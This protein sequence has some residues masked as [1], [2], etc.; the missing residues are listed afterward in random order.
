MIYGLVQIIFISRIQFSNL[1]TEEGY[2][3][4]LGESFRNKELLHTGDGGLLWLDFEHQCRSSSRNSTRTRQRSRRPHLNK[5]DGEIWRKSGKMKST[6]K[7]NKASWQKQHKTPNNHQI[8]TDFCTRKK[9]RKN[10]KG[11]G[12]NYLVK[13]VLELD[14]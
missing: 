14:Q 10:N 2:R 6:V 4:S 12:S 1:D 11:L 13:V 7:G 5:I 3:P 9:K 8:F